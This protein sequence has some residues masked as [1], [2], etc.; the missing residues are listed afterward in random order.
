[1]K[2][3]KAIITAISFVLCLS[4]L[5]N[6][7]LYAAEYVAFSLK[8]AQER[9]TSTSKGRDYRILYPEVFTLDGI[10]AVRGLVYDRK[11]KDTILIGEND[12]SR[13]TLTLD[14]FA[15]ALRARFIHGKWPLVSID[16]TEETKRTNMQIVR[17]EGGIEDTQFGQDLFDADYRLKKVG[18]G[19]LSPGIP[20]LKTCWDLWMEEAKEG[21]K[22]DTGGSRK[23][24]SRSWF[25][26]VLPSVSVREDVVA[27]K[28][29]KVGVFTEVLSA[30]IDGKEIE[31]LSTFQDIKGDIFAKAVSERFEEL[32][33]VH[34]SFLRLWGLD[35]MV[36]LTKA[37]EEMD[38]RPDLD[39]WLKEYRVKK[40]KTPRK[41][42]VLKRREDYQVDVYGMYYR[43]RYLEVSGGVH[44]MAITLRLKA[45]DVT[46]LKEAVLTARPKPDALSWSF[47]VAEWLIPTTPGMLQVEDVIPLFT[48]A[49]FLQE[50]KR[51]DDAIILYGKIIEL[52]PNW[53]LPYN[54]RGLA[55]AYQGLYDKAISNYNKALEIDPRDALAYNN[56]GNAY[57]HQGFY[58]KAISDYNKA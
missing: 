17:F 2:Y 42:K 22:R 50:N 11:T 45:G 18:M 13:A 54:N 47:I 51:Y 15:V 38:E 19:L 32:S 26:P 39:F 7:N 57:H 56:R 37:I 43:S 33:K 27:M 58:D 49:A 6:H 41:L 4:F 3:L 52:K 14:D 30:E 21:A 10:T 44:L 55:Y 34:P 24:G 35:E 9:I 12:K 16:P 31:D 48:Q 23:I 46:A 8:V 1:M 20:V 5:F 40:V 53:D 25:Y 28:G 29:L 36:A